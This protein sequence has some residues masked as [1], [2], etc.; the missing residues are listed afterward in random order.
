MRKWLLLLC[1][2][3]KMIHS[4]FHPREAAGFFPSASEELPKAFAAPS[5]VQRPYGGSSSCTVATFPAL[6]GAE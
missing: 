3:F 5:V 4:S 2:P 1:S 6:K